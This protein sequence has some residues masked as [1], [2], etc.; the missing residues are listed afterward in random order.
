MTDVP[1]RYIVFLIFNKIIIYKNRLAFWNNRL[2]SV[3]WN[4]L[5]FR[6]PGGVGVTVAE[7]VLNGAAP[8]HD[9]AVVVR[10]DAR[11]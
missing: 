9:A 6:M 2:K 10:V 5:S 3:K 4:L 11:S 8:D 7:A 1:K